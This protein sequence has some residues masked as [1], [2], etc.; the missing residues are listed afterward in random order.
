MRDQSLVGFVKMWCDLIPFDQFRLK[1]GDRWDSTLDLYGGSL[2]LY[3]ECV[4]DAFKDVLDQEA[5]LMPLLYRYD[6]FTA[7]EKTARHRTCS[8]LNLHSFF[9][10]SL[11]HCGAQLAPP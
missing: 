2:L 4:R 6:K 3:Q 5:M 10:Y 9:F 8:T 1:E 7:K 11:V